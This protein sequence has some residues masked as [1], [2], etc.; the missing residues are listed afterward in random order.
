VDGETLKTQTVQHGAA[1]SAPAAPQGYEYAWDKEFRNIRENLVVTGQKSTPV[2]ATKIP[3]GAIGIK[4]INKTI[5][6]ENLPLNAKVELFTMNGKSVYSGNSGVSH[7]LAIQVQAKGMYV[8]RITSGSEVSV[9][10]VA[11]R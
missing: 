11:V 7:S 6:L 9:S 8:A 2:V 4:A 10:R 5:H 1:A 3:G